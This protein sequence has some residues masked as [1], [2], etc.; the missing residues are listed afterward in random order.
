MME[1][2]PI[3]WQHEL[4][5]NLILQK[6]SNTDIYYKAMLFYLEEQPMLL[7]DLL[8]NLAAKIDKLDLT[9]TVSVIKRT[10]YLSLIQPFLK[11]IQS[12]NNQTVNEA[13]NDLYFEEE[14]YESLKK[15]ITQ[16]EN[17]EAISLAKQCEK[18]ELIEF[19]RVAPLLYRKMKKYDLSI[20][21]SKQDKMFRD[22]IETALESKNPDY[23]EEL[24][25]YFVDKDEKEFVTV[26][27]YTCYE[28]I[29]PS[30]C[31]EIS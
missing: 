8:N 24:L 1:H 9:K 31:L 16:Y 20:S 19:R 30:L 26:C 12:K 11:A 21:L 17:F 23:V 7:N 25:R 13:L 2:S 14:D 22:A 3:A 4:F 6:I 10:G 27:L 18:H 5:C 29:K 15:S 28:L